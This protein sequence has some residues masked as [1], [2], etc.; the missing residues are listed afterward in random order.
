MLCANGDQETGILDV[1]YRTGIGQY[2]VHCGR[3]EQ[4][5][6]LMAMKRRFILECFEL[7]E[8]SS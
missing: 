2:H 8:V 7:K 6:V 1:S 5:L 3:R 4:W